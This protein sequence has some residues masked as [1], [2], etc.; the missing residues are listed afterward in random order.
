MN[1]FT[2]RNANRFTHRT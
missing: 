1:R 2:Q